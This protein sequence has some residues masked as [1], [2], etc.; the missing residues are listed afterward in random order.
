MYRGVKQCFDPHHYG[1]SPYWCRGQCKRCYGRNRMRVIHGRK[2]TA[3]AHSRRLASLGSWVSLQ[4]R[5]WSRVDSSGGPDVC[6]PWTGGGTR[7][8]MFTYSSYGKVWT[9]HRVAWT[10]FNLQFMP[11]HM[12]AH[13]RVEDVCELGTKC[14]N[15]THVTPVTTAAHRTVHA[16]IAKEVDKSRA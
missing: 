11:S 15:P 1:G 10:L 12:M 6:W 13:H 8:G 2:A 7:Y 9:A 5:L 16:Q 3:A 14:C 4:L